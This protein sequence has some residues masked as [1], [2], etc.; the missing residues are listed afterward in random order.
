[1]TTTPTPAL[2]NTF[3]T[4]P[5]AAVPYQSNTF[6]TRDNAIAGYDRKF[7]DSQWKQLVID[8]AKL[9]VAWFVSVIV[10]AILLNWLLG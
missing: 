1:M 10:A 8:H 5:Q 7:S 4:A 9:G 6:K 2:A 3:R